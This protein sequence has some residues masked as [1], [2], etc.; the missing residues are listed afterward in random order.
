MAVA[1]SVIA[2]LGRNVNPFTTLAFIPVTFTL[3]STAYATA[4]G[5]VAIDL[6]AA[7]T[8][9]GQPFSLPYI[10]PSDVLFAL[11]AGLLSTNKFLPL[12]LAVGTATYTNPAGYPFAG[13]A[14]SNYPPAGTSSLGP[15]VRPDLQLATCPATIRLY[16]TGSGNAAAFAEI[17]DGNLTDTFTILLV[18]A[19][20][21][22][23]L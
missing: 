22:P 7:L 2:Q 17:A 21:G 23:N 3:S 6:T 12:D 14:A 8:A 13:G 9:G 16:A 4:S 10:N 15:Q 11:P 18:I 5:G 19:R 20:N 1:T